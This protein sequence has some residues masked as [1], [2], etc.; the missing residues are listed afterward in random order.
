MAIFLGTRNS[1]I[2]LFHTY[3]HLLRKARS[4]PIAETRQT[5]DETEIKFQ[6][7]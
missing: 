5:E 2:E 3:R 4:T 7:S 6:S 1:I